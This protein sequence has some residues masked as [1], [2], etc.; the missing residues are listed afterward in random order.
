MLAHVRTTH[1]PEAD[2]RRIV[3]KNVRDLLGHCR[4]AGAFVSEAAQ[5]ILV[6]YGRGSLPFVQRL[7][8]ED[9]PGLMEDLLSE[10]TDSSDETF[11][12]AV[13]CAVHLNGIVRSLDTL[14]RK[15]WVSLL[16]RILHHRPNLTWQKGIIEKLK[17]LWQVDAD[18]WRTFAEA[19][20]QLRDFKKTASLDVQQEIFDLLAIC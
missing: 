18:P 2:V 7:I 6:N 9:V 14:E 11:R 4:D 5:R 15:Q 20:E 19:E 8:A 17:I 3:G 13:Q 16:V 10:S 12:R 1:F